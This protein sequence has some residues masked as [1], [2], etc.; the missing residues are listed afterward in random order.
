MAPR[1]RTVVLDKKVANPGKSVAAEQ[2]CKQKPR[3]TR[4]SRRKEAAEPESGANEVNLSIT[5]DQVFVHVKRPELFETVQFS[6]TQPIELLLVHGPPRWIAGACF[7]Q[8]A[9]SFLIHRM[10]QS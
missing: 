3:H 9:F 10:I 5:F 6:A 1:G 4:D 7:T 8:H 2:P